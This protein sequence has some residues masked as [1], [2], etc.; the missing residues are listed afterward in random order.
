MS[1]EEDL[2]QALREGEQRLEVS[3]PDGELLELMFEAGEVSYSRRIRE[4]LDEYR[5]LPVQRYV[6]SE[7]MIQ[8]LQDIF[9]MTFQRHQRIY[10]ERLLA[11]AYEQGR[12]EEASMSIRPEA[13]AVSGTGTE[14][15]CVLCGVV[16]LHLTEQQEKGTCALLSDLIR[17]AREHQCAGLA[18]TEVKHDP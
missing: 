17:A 3:G 4:Q 8:E 9:Q 10:F 7:G 11:A 6:P 16:F 15:R 12:T 5:L 1:R 14:L 2:A 13:V 18:V